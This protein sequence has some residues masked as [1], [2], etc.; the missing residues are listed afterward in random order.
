MT[1]TQENIAMDNSKDIN[2]QTFK[3]NQPKNLKTNHKQISPLLFHKKPKLDAAVIHNITHYYA[4]TLNTLFR[5]K[6]SNNLAVQKHDGAR[7]AQW[8]DFKTQIR[9][10]TVAITLNLNGHEGNCVILIDKNL[11]YYLLQIMLGGGLS[12]DLQI[13]DR[14]LSTVEL[15]FL[16]DLSVLFCSGFSKLFANTS[17]SQSTIYKTDLDASH[18]TSF[19]D[20]TWIIANQIS[21]CNTDQLE[22][23]TI[24]W[25]QNI[26][27]DLEYLAASVSIHKNVGG[28]NKSKELWREKL[29]NTIKTLDTTIVAEISNTSIT[30][31]HASKLKVGDTII[32][33]QSADDDVSLKVSGKNI[34]HGQL[35]QSGQH[36]AIKLGLFLGQD[37]G[38][39]GNETEIEP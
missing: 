7:L 22:P 8:S 12:H 32:I 24:I 4:E 10:D 23:I 17:S 35:G 1:K 15:S 33:N 27:L 26:M 37:E 28:D 38:I 34:G 20:N 39:A 18:I 6:I 9:Q 19:D 25:N 29:L 11:M 30:L 36:V 2:S 31:H 3:N 13:I 5:T 14:E 21:I 16:D